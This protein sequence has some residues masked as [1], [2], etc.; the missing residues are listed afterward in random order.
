MFDG[1]CPFC[2]LEAGWLKRR[3]TNGHL[4]FED[5]SKP[6]FDPSQYGLTLN[7]VMGVMHAVLPDG[8]VV[9]KLEVFRQA[10]R[11]IGLGWLL[12]PTRWPI[13]RWIADAGYELFARYR[14]PL[15]RL[16]GTR[17]CQSGSCT[18]KL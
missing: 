17:N 7:E 1:Q 11:Q 13:I 6:E 3:D 5:I 9:T 2:A 18:T 8:R 10:Y 14:V 15:G 12:A 4:A 16:M